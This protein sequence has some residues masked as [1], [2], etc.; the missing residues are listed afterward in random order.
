[1]T[2]TE[3]LAEFLR[4]RS[5]AIESDADRV[6]RQENARDD[7]T[8][9]LND[10]TNLIADLEAQKR[11]VK[12]GEAEQNAGMQSMSDEQVA[13]KLVSLARAQNKCEEMESSLVKALET[14]KAKAAHAHSQYFALHRSES[15]R[16]SDLISTDVR[17]AARWADDVPGQIMY[18]VLLFSA[19]MRALREIEPPKFLS[20]PHPIWNERR[21]SAFWVSLSREILDKWKRLGELK[22]KI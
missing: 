12:D 16:V 4:K 14:L 5:P 10:F 2:S 9:A 8:W 20:S 17:A 22:T 6:R 15:S 7:L 13:T 21:D 1:M 18:Q 11:E 3:T 19:P